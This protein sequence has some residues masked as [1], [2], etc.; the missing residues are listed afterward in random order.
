M[1]CPSLHARQYAAHQG[2]NT[3]INMETSFGGGTTSNKHFQVFALV[4]LLVVQG[5]VALPQSLEA[6]ACDYTCGNNCYSNS[7]VNAAKEAGYDYHKQGKTVGSG[8]YPHVYKNY[9][10][11]DFPVDPTYYEFPILTSG[12]TFSGGSPGADRVVF[13]DDNQLAGLLTHS[14]SS[15]NGFSACQ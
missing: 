8:H 10:D 5:S 4:S 6:R 11:F 12:D 3:K 13:N 15:G 2:M 9:E 14:G 7:A 1:F